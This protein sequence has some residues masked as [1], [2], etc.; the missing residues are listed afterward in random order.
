MSASDVELVKRWY[1]GFEEGT[2]SPEICDPEIEIR[3]WDGAPLEGPYRGYEGLEQWWADFADVIEEARFALTEAHD[4]GDGRVLTIQ[5]LRGRFRL[6]GIE[7]DGLWGAIVA[8][9]DGKILSAQGYASA[10]RAKKAAGFSR[11]AG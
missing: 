5:R 2:L 10:G 9:R 4:L 7:V 6:T 1:A 8:V 11:E 3:N